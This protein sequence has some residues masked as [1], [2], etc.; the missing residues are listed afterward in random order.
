M[1]KS[2][3]QQR[4]RYSEYQAKRSAKGDPQFGTYDRAVNQIENGVPGSER[5]LGG[6]VDTMNK[7]AMT[8]ANS[9]KYGGPGTAHSQRTAEKVG[10]K[11]LAGHQAM[12]TGVVLGAGA[13]LT[14]IPAPGAATLATAGALTSF[15]VAENKYAEGRATQAKGRAIEG[16]IQRGRGGSTALGMRGVSAD[17][18]AGFVAANKKYGEKHATAK[19]ATPREGAGEM[20]EVTNAHGTTFQRRN[21]HY[22]K[23]KGD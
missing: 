14:A 9:R 11:R 17:Q 2:T 22:G 6:F 18:M 21:P 3:P 1:K 8:R 23:Q 7:V 10:E 20:V 13:V 12:A 16:S 19:T 15:M 4:E 5:A